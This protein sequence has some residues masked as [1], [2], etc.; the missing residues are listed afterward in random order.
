LSGEH[1]RVIVNPAAGRGRGARLIPEITAR[2]AEAGI[3]DVRATLSKG[4]EREIAEAAIAEGCTTIVAV[5]GDGTSANVANAILH[6]GKDVRLG[7]LPAGTGND[8]AKILGTAKSDLRSIAQS[9]AAPS[10]VRV[11]VGRIENVFFLN[12]CGFGFDVAVLEEIGRNTW[13]RGSSVYVYTALQQL[14]GFGG[15]DVAVRS[16]AIDRSTSRHMLLVI[17]NSEFF[18]GTFRIAPGASVTDGQLD[19][20]LIADIPPVRRIGMLAAATRGTHVRY[21]ECVSERSPSFEVSFDSPPAYET[22]GELHHALS[23]TLRVSSC[24][25]MLRVVTGPGFRG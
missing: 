9:C 19:A 5:G 24:P 20:I 23:S 7:V 13:L 21:A 2:F 3:T 8:F 6:S 17:A 16:E 25:S 22:D 1:V 18:G 14:F 4:H 11:D 12:C 10:D 15:V